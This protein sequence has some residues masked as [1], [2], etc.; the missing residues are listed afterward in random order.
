MPATPPPKPD[1]LT[2][3]FDGMLA[4]GSRARLLVME[5]NGEKVTIAVAIGQVE[6]DALFKMLGSRMRI[7]YMG[8]F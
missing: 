3:L 7:D 5:H 6:S 1:S 4:A 8:G 2:E